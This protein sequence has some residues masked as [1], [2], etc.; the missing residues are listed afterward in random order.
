MIAAADRLLP[1]RFRAAVAGSAELLRRNLKVTTLNL[2]LPPPAAEPEGLQAKE[3]FGI[4]ES[5]EMKSTLAEARQR[6]GQP[7]LF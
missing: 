7:E 5:M 2:A 3:L 4:L 6:Y 1:E